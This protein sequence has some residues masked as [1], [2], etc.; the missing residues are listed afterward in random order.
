MGVDWILKLHSFFD[1]K[2]IENLVV[3]DGITSDNNENNDDIGWYNEQNRINCAILSIRSLC[4]ALE[5]INSK[6]QK[7]IALKT[8]VI[9]SIAFWI[10]RKGPDQ[11]V[12][13]SLTLLSYI[14]DKNPDV[15]CQVA[16]MMVEVT[17]PRSGKTHPKGI[18]T[19]SVHYGWRPLPSDDRRFITVPAL[20]AERYIF[21]STAW[22]VPSS[23]SSTAI[24]SSNAM[25]VIGINTNKNNNDAVKDDISTPD[26][27]SVRCM[28]VLE[29][30]LQADSTTCDLMIQ[31]IL[32]P[33]PPSAS[34]DNDNFN[35][36]DMTSLE[37]MKPLALMLL[38]SLLEG[39]NRVL[40]GGG[41]LPLNIMKNEINIVE[42][43]AN[44]LTLLFIN[45]GQLARE[46]STVINTGHTSISGETD[47]NIDKQIYRHVELKDRYTY[48][49]T[50][51]RTYRQ[52]DRQTDRQTHRERDRDVV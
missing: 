42:R 14:V 44:V 45:G 18:E 21:S 19:P 30:L 24:S 47:R 29:T 20:L 12:L 31:Y 43:S 22:N 23:T 46:L 27:L 7:L 37:S 52:T 33:P 34:D 48:R 10:A 15:A 9:I 26:G 6:H 2:I 35:S 4:G 40:I 17:T 50:D 51:T 1:P 8:D 11:L 49:Q 28:H 41:N 16:D 5:I 25:N 32:A 39:S 3:N 13:F 36:G 38:N